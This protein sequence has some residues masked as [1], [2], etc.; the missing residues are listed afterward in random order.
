MLGRLHKFKET[1]QGYENYY[2]VIGGTAS[3]ILMNKSGLRAR[4]TKDVDMILI[5]EKGI[6][7]F[8]ALFWGFIKDNAYQCYCQEDGK[9]RFYRF[10]T[11][12]MDCPS[13]IEIFA[14][15]E[16]QSIEL[17]GDIRRI[18]SDEDISGLSAIIL[19]DDYYDFMMSG[20]RIVDGI[21]ILDTEYLIPFKMYAWLNNL[22][23]KQKNSK[24]VHSEDIRKH[25]NDVFR[26]LQ[27]A[28]K[29][30]NLPES[31]KSDAE[32]F[33]NMMEKEAVDVRELRFE[34]REEAIERLRELY[35][36]T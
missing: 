17:P 36:I 5:L 13:Q 14:K 26:L 12:A 33:I 9:A 35:S 6:E 34:S 15:G 8:L 16:D 28:D 24:A 20:R 22:E 18:S 23:K 27:I 7:D 1:F 29:K 4:A 21:N 31:I 32:R 10:N 2:T 3:E 25:K 19:N 30:V 11:N